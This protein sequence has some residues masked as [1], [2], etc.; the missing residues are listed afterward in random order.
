[1][2]AYVDYYVPY[3]ANMSTTVWALYLLAVLV[4]CSPMIIAFYRNV[5]NKWWLYFANLLLGYTGI[6]WTY[7]L[8]YA[9]FKS[10]QP[11]G[12]RPAIA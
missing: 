12:A 2:F 8:F 1:M 5:D 6:V 10:K 7:C 9:I 11:P 4:Y 3:N